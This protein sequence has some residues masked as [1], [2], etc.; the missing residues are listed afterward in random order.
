MNISLPTTF[1]RSFR[2]GR[3]G[4]PCA[5]VSRQGFTLVELAIVLVIIGLL[6]GVSA[7]MIKSMSQRAKRLE[8]EQIVNAAREALVGFALINSVIPGWGDDVPDGTTNEFCEVAGK[9]NDAL[10][11]ALRYRYDSRL[12]ADICSRP[13]AYITVVP[14][15]GSPVTNV[16]FVIV[17]A[18]GDYA[19]QTNVG[20]SGPVNAATT[21][22]QAGD[23]IIEYVSLYDLQGK[24]MCSSKLC[25]VYEVWNTSGNGYFRINDSACV[26][27]ANATLIASIGPG[28][29]VQRYTNDN[30]T[31]LAAVPNM[32][33][34]S[35]AQAADG[36]GDRDCQVNFNN[37]DR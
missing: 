1:S 27:V 30:C 16:A 28:G 32:L 34:Y 31:T 26:S 5:H 7:P 6:V 29:T 35:Q 37:T 9:R 22:T 17:S 12:T 14:L 13:T 24:S 18:G 23:D 10:A 33:Q 2:Q 21:F 36:A 8:T 25:G 20:A 3:A 11:Q 15:T 4:L 19:V